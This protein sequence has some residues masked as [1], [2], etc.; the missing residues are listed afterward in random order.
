MSDVVPH[1]F[2]RAFSFDTRDSSVEAAS[3]EPARRLVS[4]AR[5]RHTP[6]VKHLA[7]TVDAIEVPPWPY[8]RD[9]RG[10]FSSAARTVLEGFLRAEDAIFF[11]TYPVALAGCDDVVH[12]AYSSEFV[13]IAWGLT[14]SLS[15]GKVGKYSG[16]DLSKLAGRAFFFYP[17]G[18]GDVALR[19]DVIIALRQL[20]WPGYAERLPVMSGTRRVPYAEWAEHP[21]WTGYEPTV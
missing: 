12:V 6:P 14:A 19:G 16:I 17:P 11:E 21:E 9:V 13:D 18:V 1:L 15:D 3:G 20:G 4:R 7:F 8:F 2:Y 10:V 5:I